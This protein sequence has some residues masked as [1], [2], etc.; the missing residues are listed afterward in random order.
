MQMI[1]AAVIVI[2]PMMTVAVGGM[3]MVLMGK[4]V[5]MVVG[6]MASHGT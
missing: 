2:V 5:T 6:R 4:G 3:V 1:V